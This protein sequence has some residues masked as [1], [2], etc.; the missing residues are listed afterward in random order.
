MARRSRNGPTRAIRVLIGGIIVLVAMGTH[1][2]AKSAYVYY[3]RSFGDWSV[4]CALDEPTER[5]SCTLS[6]PPPELAASRSVVS[7]RRAADASLEVEVR[8]LGALRA[9]A[10]VY[11]R[12][13]G[14]PPWQQP[15][16]RFGVAAWRGPEA[17][18]LIDQLEQGRRLVLRSFIAGSALPRDEFVSLQSFDEAL[19]AYRKRV[20]GPEPVSDP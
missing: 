6:A 2:P 20:S 8:V 9:D 16:D 18:S 12:I 5:R 3:F 4:I 1:F 14:E 7:V 10:P 19:D 13:D 11:L 17:A 15:L